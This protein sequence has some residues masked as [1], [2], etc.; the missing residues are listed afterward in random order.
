MIQIED[1]DTAPVHPINQTHFCREKVAEF[2]DQINVWINCHPERYPLTPEQRAEWAA[3]TAQAWAHPYE[4]I[5][6]DAHRPI[7]DYFRSGHIGP[8]YMRI[9]S[10]KEE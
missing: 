9:K 7:A 3:F 2:L 1:A 10:F 8:S 5:F 4:S 6:L